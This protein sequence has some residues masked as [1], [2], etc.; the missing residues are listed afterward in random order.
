MYGI[1]V[2]VP[3]PCLKPCEQS[4]NDGSNTISNRY[5]IPSCIILS[6]G[7]GMVRGL[8]FPLDFCIYVLLAGL[9]WNFPFR[10]EP[11]A[12]VNQ[13]TDIPSNVSSLKLGVSPPGF[14]F[15]LAQQAIKK[16]GSARTLLRFVLGRLFLTPS[17]SVLNSVLSYLP[18]SKVLGTDEIGLSPFPSVE[19]LYPRVKVL[20][21]LRHPNTSVFRV[22]P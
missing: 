6:R 20:R 18:E 5:R 8:C 4:L 1:A 16:F 15:I 13:S 21:T 22:I 10:I 17:I 2:C 12:L 11:A 7:L 9:N 14:D 19:V 3:L